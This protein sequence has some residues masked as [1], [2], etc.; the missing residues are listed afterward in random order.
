MGQKD[1]RNEVEEFFKEHKDSGYLDCS[2][3]LSNGNDWK[4]TVEYSDYEN[5]KDSII[6]D[7]EINMILK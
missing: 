6:Y 3:R 2:V 7:M 1:M 5:V 4:V